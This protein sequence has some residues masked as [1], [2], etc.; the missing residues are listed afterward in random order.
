MPTNSDL[1]RRL[2]GAAALGYVVLAGVENMEALRVPLSGA[3]AAEI[4]AVYADQAL[5]AATWVAGALS[6]VLYCA[7][8]LGLAARLRAASWVLVSGLAG[9]L[10][11]ALGLVAGGVLVLG[12]AGGAT[13]ELFELQLHTRLLAG[14]PM[15][16]FLLGAGLAGL[17]T[18]ALPRPLCRLA[19]IAAAPLLLG[20]VAAVSGAHVLEVAVAVAFGGHALC[21][22]AAGLWLVAGGEGVPSLEL[23]RRGAFLLLVIAAGAVGLALLAVPDATGAF[24]AWSLAPTPLAA[25][26]GGVYV[27][28]AALYALGLARPAEETRT[29][30]LAAVVLSV[31]VLTITLAHLDVFDFGRLQAWAWVALFAG[32]AATTCVLALASGRSDGRLASRWIRWALG[33]AAL[34]LA[35]VGV[36]LWIDPAAIAGPFE[37]PALGGR[38][39]GS[40]I[41]M[42]AVLVG[43]G[44]W[45][46]RHAAAEL[47]ALALITIPGGALLGALRTFGDL[48]FAIAY[49]G[50][51]AALCAL[52]LGLA[53]RLQREQN[54]VTALRPGGGIHGRPD[55]AGERRVHR[56]RTPDASGRDPRARGPAL[57]RVGP[58]EAST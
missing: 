33:A 36:A 42:L 8:V 34:A 46:G 30:V 40:W 4:R 44:A 50:A 48:D 51:L 43:Q 37:L 20:P 2:T 13:S 5:A 25:F 49:T 24:F 41:V 18:G 38:F 29:L 47:A 39:A 56:G 19:L 28:S 15:A 53:T 55:L 1:P 21:I 52:G 6:L 54:R 17:R 14:A 23:L 16:A 26:A 27:G 35:V 32:F 11:A 45:T 12:H 57:P 22:A 9:P 7:F 31:S 3:G 10:L 58:G